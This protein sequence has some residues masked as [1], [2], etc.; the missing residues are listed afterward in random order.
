MG[1]GRGL[2]PNQIA[3]LLQELGPGCRISA[4][5]LWNR[6]DDMIGAYERASLWKGKPTA[7]QTEALLAKAMRPVTALL[8]ALEMPGC[9]LGDR[10]REEAIAAAR[11]RE[12]ELR[13]QYDIEAAKFRDE[14]VGQRGGIADEALIAGLAGIF[15]AA[16]GNRATIWDNKANGTY[17]GAFL[18]FADLGLGILGVSIPHATIATRMRRP[19]YRMSFLRSENLSGYS[20]AQ[21]VDIETVTHNDGVTDED[22]DRHPRG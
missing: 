10:Q 3:A 21:G 15:E 6:W 13:D 5:E 9:P 16:T 17:G 7:A 18:R 12:I 11:A 22:A 4:T 2:E 20:T 1:E 19:D 14:S 8:K